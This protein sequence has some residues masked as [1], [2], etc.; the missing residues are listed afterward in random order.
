[1]RLPTEIPEQALLVVVERCGSCF[2][3]DER[4][5]L[6][7]DTIRK[8]FRFDQPKTDKPR[9]QIKQQNG[10]GHA[11]PESALC[12][13]SRHEYCEHRVCGQNVVGQLRLNDC[14]DKKD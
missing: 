3:R 1:M 11:M 13:L 9:Y 12:N 5:R 10:C 8:E 7:C 2:R 4:E 14:K 6:F